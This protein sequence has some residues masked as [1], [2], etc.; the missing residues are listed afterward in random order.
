MLASGDGPRL[1]V[2][3]RFEPGTPVRL[4]A[5]STPQARDGRTVE[6]DGQAGIVIAHETI[7]AN[8]LYT[9][10][11]PGCPVEVLVDEC[12]L[13]HDALQVNQY[14]RVAGGRWRGSSGRIR[15]VTPDGAAVELLTP[16]GS[17]CVTFPREELEEW[18]AIQ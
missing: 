11:L 9:V 1:S 8:V 18:R 2:K 7:G 10:Q 16:V 4:R 17:H 5:A 14:V 12:D 15:T 13:D 3:P 6:K